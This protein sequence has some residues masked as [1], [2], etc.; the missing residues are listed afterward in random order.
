MDSFQAKVA[1]EESR[2]F[3]WH[4]RYLKNGET[5]CPL[6]GKNLKDNEKRRFIHI[7]HGGDRILRAD[8]PVTESGAAIL[9]TG[10]DTGDMGWFEVG[11]SCAKK[12]GAEYS[13]EL[14]PITG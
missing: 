6:C 10:P 11:S 14:P 9:S 7:G 12:L 1:D 4:P 8:L 5:G 2:P 13:K 3:T